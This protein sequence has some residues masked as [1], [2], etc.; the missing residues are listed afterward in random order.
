MLSTMILTAWTALSFQ[1]S[2]SGRT[3]VQLSKTRNP[4]VSSRPT[5]YSDMA[6]R[7]V[8]DVQI[9]PEMA[10]V[11]ESFFATRERM[12][13]MREPIAESAAL[14][15]ESIQERFDSQEFAPL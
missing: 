6:E 10:I 12:E 2:T 11:S 5:R 7:F 8:V 9:S 15:A 4:A 14:F 3:T 13:Q 1:T